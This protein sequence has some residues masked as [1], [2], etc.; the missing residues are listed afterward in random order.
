M[1]RWDG[2]DEF[3]AVATTG[4]FA[5][6]AEHLGASTSQMSRAVARLESKLQTQLFFRTTRKVTLTDT[7]R[8]LVE[9]CRQ[10]I[11]QRDEALDLVS[12]GDE[13]QGELR[14]TCSTAL[15]ARFVAPIVG[16]MTQRFP[17]LSINLELSNRVVDLVTEGFDLAIRTGHLPDSRLIA[18]RVASR[19]LYLCASPDYLEKAGRP[20]TVDDLTQHECLIGTATTW[21]FNVGGQER[22]FRPIGRWRCNSG[23]A[24]IEAAL[25]GLGICQLPEFY[26]L[27]FIAGGQMEVLLDHVR[28]QGEPIWAVYPQRRHLLP[29]VRYMVEQLRAELPPALG[30]SP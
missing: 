8:V 30:L 16:R 1:H 4:S 3:V 9:R 27:P 29:K 19:R 6:A 20:K 28:P 23:E 2:I 18:T 21:H 5:A 22:P 26:V 25:A 24:V 15:G 12:G 7:G 17:K 11:Q 13:P 10:V 14:L